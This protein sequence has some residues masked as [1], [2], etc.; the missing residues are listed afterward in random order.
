TP[1]DALRIVKETRIQGINVK[2]MKSGISG[3]LDIIAIAK[4][5]GRRLMI[6]CMLETRRGIN[7]SLAVA[8]GTGVFDFVDL[9]SHLLLSEADQEF[10]FTQGGPVMKFLT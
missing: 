5:G 7:A 4:A 9:D 3:A 6:G 8:C 2:L 10:Y 1:E